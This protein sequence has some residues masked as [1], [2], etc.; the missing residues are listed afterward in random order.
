M[1]MMRVE[2]IFQPERLERLRAAL[3]ERGFVSMTISELMGRGGRG[4]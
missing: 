2:V 3:E 4:E 1:A